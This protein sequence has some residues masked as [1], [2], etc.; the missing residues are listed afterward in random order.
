MRVAPALALVRD[1]RDEYASRVERS[2]LDL[3][4]S[5]RSVAQSDLH[6]VNALE[7]LRLQVSVFDERGAAELVVAGEIARLVRSKPDAVLGLATGATPIGVYAELAR[8][9]RD[10]GL[11]LSCVVT[12][13]L[14]EYLG[15]GR[16]DPRTFRRWMHEH[17]FDRVNLRDDSA[18]LPECEVS[19]AGPLDM[20]GDAP[21]IERCA[22]ECDRYERAMRSAGGIDL[23]L[24]GI[25]RNGHIGF[26]EPGSRRDSRTRMV[27]LAAATRADAA[28]RFGGLA[29]VPT[30]AVTMGIATILEA[31]SIRA[32]AFGR[33]KAEIVARALSEP[34][35]AALPATFLREHAN[36]TLF[37]DRD[38]A[39]EIAG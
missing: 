38:A 5:L 20:P 23:L 28:V 15:L 11:D 31:R 8:M 25:G 33:E 13:N 1:D 16:D 3:A 7:N 37:L 39:S 18:H 17:L 22:N 14:D 19:R 34:I 6:A 10:E 29:N 12:F 35:D 26:N 9:H 32:M 27:E 4:R 36:A 30:H 2:T 21:S 24:L